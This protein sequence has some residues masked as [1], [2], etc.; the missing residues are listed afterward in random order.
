[1]FMPG[2][3]GTLRPPAFFDSARSLPACAKKCIVPL[4][5]QHDFHGTLVINAN[6]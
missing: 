6:D 2:D 3:W 1:M 5:Q 4:A